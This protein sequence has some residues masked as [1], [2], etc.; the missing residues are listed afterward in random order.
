MSAVSPVSAALEAALSRIA[1]PEQRPDVGSS[2]DFGDSVAGALEQLDSLHKTADTL[3]VQ[4]A[5]GDLQS[6]SEYMAVATE[7]QL[8]TEVTV[9][10]RD[11]AIGAFNEI[12]RMQV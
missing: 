11:K 12:M 8:A 9:A 2:V 7:A 6:V 5:T 3:A 4:A 10:F 1:R